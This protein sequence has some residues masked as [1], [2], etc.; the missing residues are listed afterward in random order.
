MHNL[1][2]VVCRAEDARAACLHVEDYIGSFGDENNWRTIC[3]AV[4][5]AD[6]VYVHDK[7]GRW[8]PEQSLAT[9]K[10]LNE[11]VQ[12][13][14]ECPPHEEEALAIMQR[15]LHLRRANSVKLITSIGEDNPSPEKPIDGMEWYML[16]KYVEHMDSASD[17]KTKFN[18]E[19]DSFRDGQYTECGVTHVSGGEGEHF[20]VVFVDMHS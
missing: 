20:Y 4:S 7:D 2:L 18:I 6:E 12:A 17:V 16:K 11:E 19:E 9:I 10:G 14:I 13:W 1:H 8:Q 3:G 15:V 5:D